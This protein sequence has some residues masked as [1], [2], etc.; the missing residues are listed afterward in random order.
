MCLVP[1]KMLDRLVAYP[2]RAGWSLEMMKYKV[3]ILYSEKLKKYYV[4]YTKDITERIKR[5]NSGRSKFTSM[6]MPWVLIAT[7]DC[8]TLIEARRLEKTIKGRG[9]LRYLQESK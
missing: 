7:Y 9:I 4:G 5:H 8:S 1:A 2:A 6:G 3:Y